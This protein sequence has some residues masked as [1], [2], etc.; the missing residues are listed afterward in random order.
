[1]KRSADALEK[2]G[3]GSILVGIFQSQNLGLAIGALCLIFSYIFSMWE[4][5]I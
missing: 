5:K 3:V 1:L 2:I 4:A